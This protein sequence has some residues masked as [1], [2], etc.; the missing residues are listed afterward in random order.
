MRIQIKPRLAHAISILALLSAVTGC[1]GETQD[2]TP[3][4]QLPD[5]MG[6]PDDMDD[7]SDGGMPGVDLSCDTADTDGDGVCDDI[8]EDMGTDPLN[9]DSDGDGISDGEEAEAGTNPLDTDSDGD[10]VEDDDEIALGSDPLDADSDGD[11]IDDGSEVT[12]GTDP[13]VIDDSCLSATEQASISEALPVDIIITIDSSGS[14]DEEINAVRQNI[15]QNFAQIIGN[16]GLDYRIILIAEYGPSPSSNNTVCFTAPLSGEQD[17][18]NPAATPAN[19]ERFRH[20]D[21]YVHSHDAFYKMLATFDAPE[22]NGNAPT[23]W[24]EWLRPGS[25]KAFLLFT[26]DDNQG[27]S[28]ITFDEALLNLPGGHFGTVDDRNY[29]FHSIIGMAGK[30]VPTD[31]WLPTEPVE[32]NRCAPGSES[33]AVDYQKLS[34]LTGGLR[35]PLCYNENFDSVFSA[36]AQ[37]VI[38]QVLL[39]CQISVP[40][41]PAGEEVDLRGVVVQ[42]TSGIDASV[43]TLERAETPG[44]CGDEAFYVD[45]NAVVLCETMCDTVQADETGKLDFFFACMGDL[46]EPEMCESCDDC[47]GQACV[48]GECGE[49]TD[50]SECCPGLL[51]ISGSCESVGG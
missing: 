45:G 29:I 11:G 18:S 36:I 23:G 44:T 9:P 27:Y 25:A 51:C 48:D 2:I 46:P 22:P 4:G 3:D 34:I 32:P 1:P 21:S 15:N 47:G 6:D 38:D 39:P 20:Y 8:E 31:A 19:T 33:S 35:F 28:D 26:D 37:G 49:C 41:A 13:S 5:G 16:S 30:T 43:T 12:L 40:E 10:G 7:S 50:S 14:M 42:Y 17:C 24:Q